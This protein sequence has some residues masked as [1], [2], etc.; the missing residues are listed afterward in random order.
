MSIFL[1]RNGSTN[2]QYYYINIISCILF[3]KY[4]FFKYVLNQ[5]IIY[6]IYMGRGTERTLWFEKLIQSKSSKIKKKLFLKVYINW[7]I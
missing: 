1:M 7:N 3:Y 4:I 6:I 5:I 2:C